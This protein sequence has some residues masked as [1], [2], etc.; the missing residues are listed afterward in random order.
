M[1]CVTPGGDLFERFAYA[2]GA[3]WA[4][5]DGEI[6]DELQYSEIDLVNQRVGAWVAERDASA[7]VEILSEAR[8]PASLVMTPE[9]LVSDPHLRAAGAF[10]S[11]VRDDGVPYEM[12]AP[13]PRFGGRRR[14]VTSTAPALGASTFEVL[15]EVLGLGTA[16]LEALRRD[17]VI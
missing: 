3:D 14:A 10:E 6:R 8:I 16:E 4:F 2:I 1:I 9:M 7:A 13:V 15:G 17:G 12:P 11:H 5:A